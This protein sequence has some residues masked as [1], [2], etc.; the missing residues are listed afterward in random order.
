MNSQGKKKKKI[1][2]SAAPLYASLLV[3]FGLTLFVGIFWMVNEYQAYEESVV[4][5]RHNFQQRYQ[6]RVKEEHDKLIDFIEYKRSQ[7]EQ[8]IETELRDRV[9]TAYTIAAHISSISKGKKSVTALRSMVSEVLRPI[10]WNNGQGYYF[11]FSVADGSFDLFADEPWFEGRDWALLNQVMGQDV[12]TDI[13]KLVEEKGAGIYGYQL[14]KPQFPGKVYPSLAFIKYF[15]PFDWVI[16]AA[17]YT[18]EIEKELQEMILS[19]TTSIHFGADGEVFG[20]R[21]DGTIIADRDVQMLGRSVRNLVDAKGVAY[22]TRMLD[23]GSK[24]A[25]GGYVEYT[26]AAA[27]G[28][29][30]RQ[31]SYVCGYPEWGWL[32]ATTMSMAEMEAAVARETQ[33]Y[34]DIAF[35][36]VFIF[37]VLFVV[38]VLLLVLVSYV[39]SV[40][41]KRGLALFTDFFRKAADRKVRIRG[42]GL[43]FSEFDELRVLANRMVDDRIQQEELLRRDELRLDTLL[44]LGMMEG[45][46]LGERYDFVLRRVVRITRSYEGYLALVDSTGNHLSF[47]AMVTR[48]SPESLVDR[49]MSLRV[50]RAGLAG[51]AVMAK[52]EILCNSYQGFQDQATIFPYGGP[53]LRHIDVPVVDDGKIV[54]VVGVCN[55]PRAYDATDIRQVKMLVEGLWLHVL[56]TSAEKELAR[57]ERQII[58]VSEEERSNVGRDLH[59]NLGSHLAGVEL[60]SKALEQKLERD[61]PEKAQSLGTIRNLIRDAIEKTRRLAQGLYPAHVIEHGLEAAVEELL[62]E[63]ENLFRVQCTYSFEGDRGW[64]DNTV[65]THVYYIIREAVF[66]AARHGQPDNIGIFMR[67]G[68]ENFAVRVVDDG[69]GF[70]EAKSRKGLGYHTMQYRAK[71]IGAELTISSELNGGTIVS[72][73]GEVQNC[74]EQDTDR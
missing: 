71:A 5:I 35:K 47:C 61:D 60:L 10:R 1:S 13:Q 65:A 40:K 22:G 74:D 56:K 55:N 73:E 16:G 38:A 21:R 72:I 39:Y 68:A 11:V 20:F 41:I 36:N 51:A 3:I 25:A 8:G 53:V 32:F 31:L 48:S 4:T 2:L 6:Q 14:H 29:Q 30:Q 59:D 45:R 52:Q 9:G 24:N 34:R 15:K 33:S 66:N 67:T 54:M 27:G 42:E 70:D 62:N 23:V 28:P 37:I 12:L 64:V 7:V 44:C 69:S 18:E 49:E 63:A 50:H 43:A 26:V 46:S 17:V 19:W 57:L 58:A